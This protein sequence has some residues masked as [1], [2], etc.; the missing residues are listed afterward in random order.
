[1][2]RKLDFS[3]LIPER[4][5][6]TDADGQVYEFLNATDFGAVEMA[7]ITRYKAALDAGLQVLGAN[8]ADEQA[9]FAI[10]AACNDILALILPKLPRERL[11]DWTMGQKMA[12]ANFWKHAQDEKRQGQQAAGEA[13]AG[14]PALP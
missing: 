7:R 3:S 6:F 10:E 8:N 13:P 1:M 12:I 11:G 9:A 14:Q 5:T 4:D 2:T